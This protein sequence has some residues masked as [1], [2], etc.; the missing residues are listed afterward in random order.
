MAIALFVMLKEG[1]ITFSLFALLIPVMIVIPG[2][3]FAIYYWKYQVSEQFEIKESWVV[4]KYAK[5]IILIGIGFAMANLS[6][7][8]LS[9]SEHELFHDFWASVSDP[10][11]LECQQPPNIR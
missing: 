2:I 11:T 10:R 1:K 4:V 6:T 8:G 3:A 9:T 5:G 7:T